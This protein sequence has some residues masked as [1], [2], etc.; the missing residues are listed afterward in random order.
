MKLHRILPLA[1]LAAAAC[2]G[3]ASTDDFRAEAPTSAK[4]AISQNDSDTA[5]GTTTAKKRR[6]RAARGGEC[7]PHLFV[8][9]REIVGRVNRHFQAP[10]PR[11]GADPQQPL[12][13]GE[14]K[15]WED[16]RD[17]PTASSP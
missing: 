3:S 9:T 2:G 5:E 8:R 10:P 1:L 4:L 12:A 15:T 11:R 7:H 16:V 13:D 17:G 6:P 14:T